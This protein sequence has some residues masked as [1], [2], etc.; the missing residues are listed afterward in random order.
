MTFRF[1]KFSVEDDRS[2][3]RI[4]T[5]AIL[6]GAW[7]DAGKAERILE[8]GTGCGVIALMMAQ[9]S[10][11]SVDAIDINL[12]SVAQARS[13]FENCPWKDRLTAYHRSFREHAEYARIKYD[14]ILTNPPFFRNSLKS[15]DT[16]RNLARHH[17]PFRFTELFETVN[18]LLSEKGS[19]YIIL[20]ETNIVYLRELA[21]IYQLPVHQ[22]L[23]IKPKENKNINRVLMKF[24]RTKPE[25]ETIE[26][27]TLRH[28]DNSFTSQY[29][30]L[31]GNFYLSLP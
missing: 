22:I 18:I 28:A 25:N 27:L 14:I 20:P 19:F 5:D 1:R 23:N 29:K 24:C 31:T 17:E 26:E 10:N 16:K 2:T 21:M 9:K 8:I 12:E 7:I 13:N 15:T 3:M 11:A 6:L 4:G 30:E